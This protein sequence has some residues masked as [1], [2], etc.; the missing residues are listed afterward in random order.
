MKI[1]QKLLLIML[2]GILVP[3]IIITYFNYHA[4]A[5]V[6]TS[7]L[8]DNLKISVQQRINYLEYYANHMLKS[9]KI[10]S[11]KEELYSSYINGNENILFN[12]LSS[13]AKAHDFYD[14]FI[15]SKEGQIDFTLKKESDYHKNLYEKPFLGGKFSNG[16]IQSLKTKKITISNFSYY[17]PSKKY[18]SFLIIPILKKGEVTALLAA[19]LDIDVFVKLSSDYN[20]LGETGEI[21]FAEEID[22]RA[23]FI[24][25]LRYDNMEIFNRYVQLGAK[26]G[27]PIQKAVRGEFG[28]GIYHDYKN[29][30]VIASWGYIKPFHIG[31]VVKVDLKEAYAKLNHLRDTSILMGIIIL[32]V[33]L[34]LSWYMRR[35]VIEIELKRIQYEY[36]ISG[37]NDGL[38]DW[39]IPKN[40]IYFSPQLKKMLGYKDDEFENSLQQWESVVHPDDLEST[41][42]FIEKCHNNPK[43]EYKIEY[44]AKHKDGSWIWILDRGHT[45][46]KNTKAVRMIGFHTNITENKHKEL[47]IQEVHALLSDII[48]SIENLIFVKDTNFVYIECNDAFS[49]FVGKNKENIIGKTDYELFDKDIADL[50]RT[51]DRKMMI[52]QKAQT[53]Y[54]WV[55]YPDG[56]DIYL[57]TLKAP[58]HDISGNIKGIVGNAVDMT[59]SYNDKK[60]LIEKDEIMIAQSR[61]AAM[62]EMISMIAHQ[63]RQPI[64]VISMDANN[65]LVDIELE[66]LNIDSLKNDLSDII[67]QTEYLSKTIDDFRNFFKPSKIKDEILVSDVFLESFNVISKS[68]KNNNIKIVNE[69][70]SKTKVKLFS[71]EL[72]QVFINLLKNSKE[73]LVENRDEKRTILNKIYEDKD[74]VIVRVCDNAGG[75]EKKILS[76]IFDPYFSTKNTKNGTGLGLYMSKTIIEKHLNGSIIAFNH[77]NGVCFEIRLPKIKK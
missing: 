30:N 10:M 65:V 71:R 27:V 49:K 1:S 16:F 17:E 45:I 34:Y 58:L 76:K 4:S 70:D 41:L 23:V 39:N 47:K 38:W 52:I 60:S 6:I 37:T 15:I 22:N 53:N 8:K 43:K 61:H 32:V 62:G 40:T 63:W 5:K 67:N 3:V 11:E 36:A 9:L 29:I 33:I 7:T 56:K 21:I 55:T 73:A 44:R 28:S 31:M 25:K 48:N 57:Y 75:I 14:I 64:S 26:N 46:F 13:H 74:S 2:L 20:G 77:N 19:Q 35:M 59:N 50:F 18:A 24:N 66:D 51:K 12:I 72:L 54:E 69:F 42:Q 68:M